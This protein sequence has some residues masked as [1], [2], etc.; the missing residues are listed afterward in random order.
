MQGI[1][2]INGTQLITALGVEALHR[3]EKIAIQAD[4]VAALSI[5]V[6]QGT[7]RAFEAGAA[8]IGFALVAVNHFLRPHSLSQQWSPVLLLNKIIPAVLKHVPLLQI[9]TC[10]DLMLDS[11]KLLHGCEPCL[12]PTFIP[13][14]SEVTQCP[15][16][17]SPPL[18]L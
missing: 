8:S 10:S 15:S 5:D 13:Q 2:L 14:R 18:I 11:S 3:A 16:R 9:F 7:P 12:T 1:A 4:I 17:Y 6:L